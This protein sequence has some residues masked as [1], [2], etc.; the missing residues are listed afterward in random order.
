MSLS[1]G[2]VGLPNVGKSTLFNALLK[3]QAALA[4]NYPFATIDPNIGIVPV[5]DARLEVLAKMVSAK[6]IKPAVVEFVDIAGLVSGASKGEGLGNKFLANIRETDLICHVVRGFS[7]DLILR[8]GS[9]DPKSDR[10]VIEMELLLADITT[11]EKQRQPK[12]TKD[13]DLL[14]KWEVVQKMLKVA[15][16]GQMIS[17]ALASDEEKKVGREMGLLTAKEIIYIINVDENVISEQDSQIKNYAD[18][19]S[20]SEDKIVIISAKIESEIAALADEDSALFLEELGLKKSGLERLI[21]TAYDRLGLQTYLTAGEMEVKAWT[22]KKG[23]LAPQAAG[24][25]HT[26]FEKKFIKAKVVS[27]QDFLDFDGWKGTKEK[28]KQR[29]EGKDYEMRAD[30]VV[31]F[32]IGT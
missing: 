32:M 31:E 6:A 1:V 16:D 9:T 12:A 27:Y 4:A 15:I 11:L 19:L 14:F 2:I 29:I 23:T 10:E 3:R 18:L 13:K 7:D 5:P 21:Q 20:V 8:E 24:V 28:G 17:S 25:I 22:I 30:D 26:D